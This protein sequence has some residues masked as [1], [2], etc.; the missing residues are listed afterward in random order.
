MIDIGERA[1]GIDVRARKLRGEQRRA[2]MRRIR[3]QIC[4]V[5]ILRA[6][7]DIARRPMIEIVGIAIAG[8]RRIE[9]ERA[10]S[11]LWTQG[12]DRPDRLQPNRADGLQVS[13]ATGEKG[14]PDAVQEKIRMLRGIAEGLAQPVHRLVQTLLKIDKCIRWP[15]PFPQLVSGYQLIGAF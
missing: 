12:A 2:E 13:A 8:V 3:P 15:Q 10:V 14:P 6:A 9:H 11:S 1:I 4:D 5:R 7:H